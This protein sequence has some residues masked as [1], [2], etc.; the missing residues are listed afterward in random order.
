MRVPRVASC[1]VGLPESLAEY[2]I[3]SEY[4][5]LRFLETT[6]VPAPRAFGYGVRGDGTDHGV[7]VSFLLMEEL[8]G[9]PWTGEGASGEDATEAEKAKVWSGLAAILA[10]LARHPF[11]SPGH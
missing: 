8:P 2:L 7:G 11:P 5:T 6:A 4:A 3:L 10:E 1:A 9:K